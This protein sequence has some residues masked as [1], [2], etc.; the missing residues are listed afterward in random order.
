[1]LRKLPEVAS[2]AGLGFGRFAERW[3]MDGGCLI[4]GEQAGG[5]A[6]RPALRLEI[7]V[8]TCWCPMY[9]GG[10]KARL[11]HDHREGDMYCH[12]ER[13]EASPR[14]ERRSFA[15]AQDD[16]CQNHRGGVLPA[17]RAERVEIQR[18]YRAR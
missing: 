2:L 13:S 16:T 3:D 6:E 12:A 8:A 18:R 14:G 7:P 1:M 15:V 9:D 5:R 4:V 10:A 11:V 17:T